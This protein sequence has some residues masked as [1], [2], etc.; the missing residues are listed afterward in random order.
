M[1]TYSQPIS[2]KNVVATAFSYGHNFRLHDTAD[3]Y[4]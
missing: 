2:G 4:K 3:P 1:A